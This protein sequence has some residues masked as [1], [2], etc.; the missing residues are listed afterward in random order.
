MT[1]S[2]ASRSSEP[3]SAATRGGGKGKRPGGK[4][5]DLTLKLQVAGALAA[6]GYHSRINV[7]LSATGARG[8][9]DVTDIDVLAIRYDLMFKREVVAVSCKSGAAKTLSPARE[10]FYLR[11]VLDYVEAGEGVAAFSQKPIAPHLRDLG[12]RLGVLMLSGDEIRE[13]CAHL[14]NGIAIPGYFHE[15]AYEGYSGAWAKLGTTGLAEYLRT[16]Y[17]FHFDFRNLQNVMVHARKAMP[18]LTGKEPWHGI[19]AWDTAAHLCL[20]IFDL[21]RQVRMLG[22]SAIGDT[23]PAYLFGGAASLKARRDLYS[24][25]QQLLASTGVMG[26]TGPALPALEPPYSQALAELA[27]RFIERP[28]SAVLI[29]L[30]IQDNVWRLLG[31][32]GLPPREDKTFLAAEKLTQDLLDFIKAAAAIQWMP[33]V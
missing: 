16:D 30:I 29:P 10:A 12:Q 19:I 33:H 6:C 23:T 14:T 1:S 21:C 31:A 5:L 28:H 25:V 4:D 11:G 32:E 27:V 3:G 17:W 26:Q 22:L 20:T 18:R 2:N 15:S 7:L 24:R 13:W 9:A 8:L